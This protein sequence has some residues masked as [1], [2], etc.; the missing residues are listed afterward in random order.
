MINKKTEQIID[1]HGKAEEYLSE[2]CEK[3]K[4][5]FLKFEILHHEALYV[6]NDL[7]EALL[8]IEEMIT[9]SLRDVKE[10]YIN[11]AASTYKTVFK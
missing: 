10:A 5:L 2:C 4:M 7:A 6:N 3:R 8:E 1:V 9:E 11:G